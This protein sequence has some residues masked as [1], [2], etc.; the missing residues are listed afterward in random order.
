MAEF[1]W[2]PIPP[3][4][5][6]S[7]GWRRPNRPSANPHRRP[8]LPREQLIARRV[9]ERRLSD[10][11]P[12][13]CRSLPRHASERGDPLGRAFLGLDMIR[14][15]RTRHLGGGPGVRPLLRRQAWRRHLRQGRG[16]PPPRV[17][18]P[19]SK[20]F[21]TQSCSTV[22][23]GARDRLV[24]HVDASP[25]PEASRC[26]APPARAD[27]IIAT[28]R[29]KFYATQCLS[30]CA[31]PARRRAF[32][33]LS[34]ARFPLPRRLD[35]AR[36][37]DDSVEKIKN[38]VGK[39]GAAYCPAASPGGGGGDDPRKRSA[40]RPRVVD[41]GLFGWAKPTCRDAVQGHTHPLVT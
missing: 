19:R 3:L 30:K 18:P 5:P 22:C 34:Y 29:A 13:E 28:A 33:K 4:R 6:W 27:A 23:G 31:Q 10:I 41:H 40:T 9:R 38:T 21:W 25:A 35:D 16:R 15:L 12:S 1:S 8:R 11:L 7:E 39:G 36:F 26:S 2:R 17:R 24:S 14:H 32:A 20:S 37:R